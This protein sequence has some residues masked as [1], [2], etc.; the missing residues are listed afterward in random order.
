MQV[1]LWSLAD[2]VTNLSIHDQGTFDGKREK[3]SSR[4]TLK[5]SAACQDHALHLYSQFCWR[6]DVS[7]LCMSHLWLVT[8]LITQDIKASLLTFAG[9]ALLACQISLM[10]TDVHYIDCNELPP[11]YNTKIDGFL[12]LLLDFYFSF[13]FG[14]KWNL[15]LFWQ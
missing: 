4:L 7:S 12:E 15:L 8:L 5:V 14:S 6:V 1:V 11:A 13:V 3:L 9:F 2:H 10:V